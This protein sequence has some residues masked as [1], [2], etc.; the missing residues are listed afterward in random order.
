MLLEKINSPRDLK[1]L[2][3]NEL[4][5]LAREIREVLLRK[6]SEKGGHFG[7][8]F[9][10]VEATI[11][12]HYIF[13]SP[14][15]KIVFDVSHQS[16]CHKIL[17][18]RKEAFIQ[19]E[20][21]GEVTGYTCPDESEHDLFNIGHTSTSISLACGLAK[22]R[23]LTGGVENIIAVI[24]DGA[25]SG[26]EALEGLDYAYELHSNLIIV[27]NDNGM[28][29]ADNHGG[30]YQNLKML[31]DT[32]GMAECNLFRALGF[33]YLFVED[34]N[35]LGQ[36]VQAFEKVKNS[37]HPFVVHI[38]T[39]KGKGYPVAEKNPEDW[40][41]YPPFDMET[42]IKR[43][44]PYEE[45]YDATTCDFLLRKIK[46]DRSVVALVAAVPLTIGFTREKRIAAGEQ[47]V[48]VGIA[49]EHAVAMAAGI[50]RRGG[51]PIFTTDAS[52]FQRVYDQISQEICINR[53]PVTLLVRN[54]SIF[55]MNDMTHLGIFD[56]PLLSNIPNLV[57]LAPTNKQEYL[58]MLEWSVEQR[59]YPV[60]IRIP[61]Y[62]V[63]TV[64]EPVDK[65]YGSLNKYKIVKQGEDIAVIALGDFYQLGE[66]VVEEVRKV[67]GIQATLIN[68]RYITGVDH[69]I[70]NGL[71]VNHKMVITLEDGIL[72]GGFGEKISAFYG[73]KKMRV[74]NYGLKK[75]F[76]DRYRVDELMCANR[77][78]S[79]QI[80]EDIKYTFGNMRDV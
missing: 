62:K 29:I 58:A 61:R 53:L 6:L 76:V 25:L 2:D 31:R 40:H 79:R 12:L 27:I 59:E 73:N 44:R 46:E 57:Y 8:N 80:V 37:N 74:I 48:D 34:G 20:H 52:F 1:K 32:K 47:F 21:Y 75:E 11:A 55:G 50:A 68:P 60:A 43:A 66:E 49:E 7:S 45:R 71:L 67:I 41:W 16:Y 30:L 14:N 65:E 63:I 15:D 77:L 19:E 22:A 78:T 3:Q 51:K 42:G 69:E 70:L 54:A 23:D 28:S 4:I 17:T 13:D 18:G 38:V 33:D 35:D 26:G 56:I 24:G 10:M 9:G 39:C 36:L 64:K 5:L 72:N